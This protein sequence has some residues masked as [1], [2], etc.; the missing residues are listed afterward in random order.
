MK[1][2]PLELERYQHF[3]RVAQRKEPA[4]HW[5]KSVQ[6]L[7]V[8]TGQLQRS[9]VALAEGRVA[10]V[11][12]QEPCVD[13]HTEV[14][15]LE[16]EQLLVPG[17]IEPHAHPFQWYNP[18]SWGSYLIGQGTTTSINDNMALFKYLNDEQALS[19][20]EE[21]DAGGDHLWLWWS[22]FDAQTGL[23]HE[24]GRFAPETLRRWLQHRLVVQGG[25]FTSWPLLLKG[26]KT[27]AEAMLITKRE[28]NKRVEGHLPG[29][30]PET[31]NSMVAAGVSADHEALSGEDVIQ[32]LRLGLY[33]TLRYSSI[34]P[35]LPQLL[36]EIKGH[37]ELNTS[38]LLLTNDGSMPFF[39][40]QSGVNQ[41]IQLVLE[42]G[43]SP[44]D[45]YRMATLNPATYYGL[46]EELGGIAPGRLAHLNI[47]SDLTQPT[48][49]HV[50][51]EGKWVVQNGKKL[52]NST[53]FS[54]A[55]QEW[56]QRVFPKL[57]THS[58]PEPKDLSVAQPPIGI[59]LINEVITKPYE[60]DPQQ[61]LAGDESYLSLVD[62][63]GKWVINTRIKGFA[64][65]LLA[66]ASTYSASSHYLLI[67]SD[68]EEMLKALN[69]TLE[70]GG[71]IYAKFSQDEE[72][73]V[74][75]PLGGGMSL[76][77]MEQLI[78]LSTGFV[79]QLRRHGHP[80]QDPIYTLLF[81]TATHLPFIRLTD[82]GLYLIK[83]QKLIAPSQRL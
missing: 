67:G 54:L 26:N 9:H 74:P 44:A 34:R 49:L 16:R 52:I 36:E 57:N 12:E 81:L 21:L 42:A 66:L 17:Y 10:Y 18:Y 19:F 69:H 38:R 50:M 24:E 82:Q 51:V 45:A 47:L 15:E 39:V 63:Q 27:L 5:F 53:A 3:I 2:R 68:R 78:T 8:Y 79:K 6:L 73:W 14:I 22:R 58:T 20:I 33:A 55:H 35:D 61:P 60:F 11:G 13:H 75:L 72:L 46:E 83:E 1:I 4:T 37:P 31:L 48:P 41:M 77:P 62:R 25:E 40:E 59:E 32:R 29:S 30:S 80:F 43:F 71:G 70:Q 76:E 64:T 23:D 65:E 7:N 56:L 28:F